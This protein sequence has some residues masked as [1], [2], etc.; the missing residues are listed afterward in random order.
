MVGV[1]QVNGGHNT[2]VN[3]GCNTQV[4]GDMGTLEVSFS[5]ILLDTIAAV[6]LHVS[7]R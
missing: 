1:T 3:D 2:Q 5:F 6:R 7:M 4:N